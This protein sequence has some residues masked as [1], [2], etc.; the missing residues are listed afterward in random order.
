MSDTVR[1]Y[2]GQAGSLRSSG[3]RRSG[4]HVIRRIVLP[5]LVLLVLA[6]WWVTRDTYEFTDCIPGGQR[7]TM[8]LAEPLQA[9]DRIVQSRVWQAIP[10]SW[11]GPVRPDTLSSDLG[12][13][14]WVL[15]NIV[16]QRV[17]L[18]GNRVDE[19]PDIVALTRMTRI[20]TILERFHGWF[21][22]VEDDYAGGL[23]LRSIPEQDLYYAVRG[24]ILVASPS[25]SALIR[26]LTLTGADTLRPEK[27]DELVQAGNEDL[28][29]TWT[30]L[31][32]S[33]LAD[34]FESIA[35]AVRIDAD[36]AKAKCRGRLRP[37]AANRL[38]A[39]VNEARPVTLEQP[40][41]GMIELS[42]NLGRP[43]RDMWGSLGEIAGVS[44]LSDAQ[45]KAWEEGDPDRPPGIAQF[46]T[47]LLGEAGPGIRLSLTGVDVNE[48]VPMPLLAGT[49]DADPN[50]IEKD[51]ESIPPAPDSVKPWDSVPRYEADERLAYVPM[52][53][54][55]SLEPAA[56]F[57][58]DA[59]LVSSSRKVAEAILAT[60]EPEQDLSEPGNLFI[61][62]HPA[63]L[64]EAI[65]E[66]GR[67]LAEFNG[68]R[69]YTG[70]SF[71]DA[72]AQWKAS[73]SVVKEVSALASIDEG[74]IDLELRVVCGDAS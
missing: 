69:G 5:L 74:A 63:P 11:T 29:G 19:S 68:L 36:S 51:F 6:G 53:G 44:W 48:M 65:T 30:T 25:R 7:F 42:A 45:W 9:R 70:D 12:L 8:V 31:A 61:R 15:N 60:N 4:R 71:E 34:T 46:I 1:N 22:G 54:G 57:Y 38:A 40:P 52:I 66:S 16:H 56:T 43:I 72:A 62:V 18:T 39:V 20:G 3:R 59:L 17:I 24:R 32:G 33:P 28:R 47:N 67:L 55:P 10:A 64:V 13:P 27:F 23:R 58:H 49:V 26:A 37:D 21:S 2:T 14:E 73:A 50:R 35:F 41:P